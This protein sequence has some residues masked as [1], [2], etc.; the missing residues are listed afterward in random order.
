MVYFLS[1]I[2]F[3]SSAFSFGVD[4]VLYF[5]LGI[6]SNKGN[7][8]QNS[9]IVQY[10][11]D[12]FHVFFKKWDDFFVPDYSSCIDLLPLSLISYK[13]FKSLYSLAIPDFFF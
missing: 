5:F 12:F 10:D 9:V 3:R 2:E 7:L 13:Y 11:S 4:S 6:Y 1:F 8:W